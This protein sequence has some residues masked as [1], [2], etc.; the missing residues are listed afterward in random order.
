MFAL[1]F[2]LVLALALLFRPM[3]AYVLA[4]MVCTCA[5]AG[6]LVSAHVRVRVCTCNFL[7]ALLFG[8]VFLH[9]CCVSRVLCSCRAYFRWWSISGG[10]IYFLIVARACLIVQHLSL[11]CLCVVVRR[12]LGQCPSS[13]SPPLFSCSLLQL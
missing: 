8:A 6:A 4:L 3:F 12:V 7:T 10:F 5:D 2:A 13:A 9:L 1:V 11:G